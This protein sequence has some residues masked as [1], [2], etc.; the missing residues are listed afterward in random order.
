VASSSRAR[1]STSKATWGTVFTSS[2]A[3]T[4]PPTLPKS[5]PQL[6]EDDGLVKAAPLAHQ[7]GCA[8]FSAALLQASYVVGGPPERVLLP[9]P[10]S[11]SEVRC[12]RIYS[13]CRAAAKEK[14]CRPPFRPSTAAAQ[15]AAKIGGRGRRRP[16]RP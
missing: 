3:A 6:A 16:G 1:S 4:L 9:N 8:N 15:V 7:P 14:S 10:C 11:T 5:G 13:F 2:A 12:P